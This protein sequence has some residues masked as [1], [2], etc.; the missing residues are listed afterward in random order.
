LFEAAIA[1]NAGPGNLAVWKARFA[2]VA[3]PL[4]F[5]ELV[6]YRETRAY[7]ERVMANYW[8]YSLRLGPGDTG[9]VAS[10][11]AV[12]G[13]APAQYAFASNRNPDQIVVGD[14]SR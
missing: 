10:L 3:D 12:A 4:L 7:V 9:G 5:I 2:D 13:G 8:I 14:I 1:Y 6:P 11:D